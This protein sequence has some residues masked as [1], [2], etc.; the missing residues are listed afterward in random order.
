MSIFIVSQ[1]DQSRNYNLVS[2]E[3]KRLL[4]KTFGQR[5]EEKL[6]ELGISMSELA[7]RTGLSK[8]VISNTINNPNREMR[9]SS[10]ISIARVLKVDPIWLYT[11]RSSGDLL[12]DIQF[13]S[14]KVPVWTLDDVGNLATDMLPNMNSG[15]Y[16]VAENQSHSIAIE[17]TNDHLSKSGIVAGDICIFSLAD[18]TPEE[19]AVMLIRLE[20]NDQ[21]RLLRAMSGIDGWVYGVDDPR[22]G[23]VTSSEAIVL[24][25][26]S[27]LR[28]NEIK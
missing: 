2:K 17:A 10:L 18:R 13:N 7:R 4:M 16:V 1:S 12:N 5:L 3:N 14:D 8:S 6:Q 15:R 27:E 23:T 28:R 20:K 9:V 11:G 26:L 21:A 22:L 19:G 24:G 25:K